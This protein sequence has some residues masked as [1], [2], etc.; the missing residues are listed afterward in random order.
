MAADAILP[1]ATPT[2]PAVLERAWHLL[3]Q[4]VSLSI[5]AGIQESKLKSG[6]TPGVAA[7]IELTIIES[8]EIVNLN[9]LETTEQFSDFMRETRTLYMPA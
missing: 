7:A 3:R 4:Y 6:V 2:D 5:V 9:P 8:A 1:P